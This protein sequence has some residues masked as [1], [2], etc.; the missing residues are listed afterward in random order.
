MA[1][2]NFAAPAILRRAVETT[3]FPRPL[4][5]EKLRFPGI[6]RS[7]PFIGTPQISS[8]KGICDAAHAVKGD[9]DALLKGVVGDKN[10]IEAV[11]QILEM[12]KRASTRREV[13]YTDFL[14]PPI[15]KES[16]LLLEK[17]A[18]IKGVPQGGY[19]QAERCRLSV[20]HF[21]V[22][23]SPPDIVAALRST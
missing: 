21:E 1:A 3:W 17:L 12:A 9:A 11:K 23:T 6:L 19:P 13:L 14:T 2:T 20:G 22:M 16:M 4:Y 10:S 18:D 15:L 5:S 8:V 7:V